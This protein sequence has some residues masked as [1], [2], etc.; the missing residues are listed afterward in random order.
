MFWS[1]KRLFRYATI[2]LALLAATACE[3]D[4][5]TEPRPDRLG[6]TIW[7]IAYPDLQRANEIFDLVAS[8]NYYLTIDDEVEGDTEDTTV[9]ISQSE[10]Y[11]RERLN[12]PVDIT[13]EGNTHTLTYDTG[14]GTTYG[15]TFV[16]YEDR[17]EVTRTGGNSF[18]LT[19]S[20]AKEDIYDVV[21]ST[22]YNSE[23]TGYGEFR[24]ELHYL[25]DGTPDIEFTG[26]LVMVDGESSRTHPL[27]ITTRINDGLKFR[28]ERG[29]NRVPTKGRMTITAHDALYNTTDEIT[30]TIIGNDYHYGVNIECLYESHGYYF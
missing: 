16:M 11:R 30:A 19:I 29:Y 23:S 13:I 2:A 8:Y 24:A 14:Y 22:I 12:N 27:T 3:Y 26:T 25:E 4:E 17:W 1:M 15:I 9:D 10:R 21:A 20:H 7:D 6:K 28:N 5:G 18:S